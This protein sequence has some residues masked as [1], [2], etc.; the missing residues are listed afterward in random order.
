MDYNKHGGSPLLGCSKTIIKSHGSSKAETIFAAIQLAKNY[1]KANIN[2]KI[3]ETILSL[4]DLE[5]EGND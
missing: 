5:G 1:T 4:P 3:S 2:G